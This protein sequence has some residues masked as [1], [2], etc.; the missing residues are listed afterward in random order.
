MP[1]V[2]SHIEYIGNYFSTIKN[3]DKVLNTQERSARP[4]LRSIEYIV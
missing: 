4:N 2:L 3:R 1:N